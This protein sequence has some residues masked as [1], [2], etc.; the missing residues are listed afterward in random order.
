[1]TFTGQVIVRLGSRFFHVKK[2]LLHQLDA[3]SKSRE[4]HYIRVEVGSGDQFLNTSR[5]MS[6]PK[7]VV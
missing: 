2:H 3:T 5:L 1:M 4:W 7:R 6:E